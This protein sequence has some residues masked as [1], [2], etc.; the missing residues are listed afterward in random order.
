M[1][2]SKVVNVAGKDRRVAVINYDEDDIKAKT[3]TNV[4]QLH[5]IHILDRSGSM[6]REIDNLIDSVQ[7]TIKVIHDDDLISIIWFSSPGQYRTLIKGA[8]KTDGLDKLLD[9]LRSTIATTCF[10]DPLKEA[11]LIIDELV[12]L[13]PN[14]SI[15]LFT[16]GCPVIPWSIEE[17]EKRIFNILNDIKDKILAFN[18][19]GFGNWYN[20]DLLTKMAA[21]SEYGTFVHSTKIDEYL[22]IFNHN[23]EKISDMVF[24]SVTVE[25]QNHDIV[26]LTRKFSKMEDGEF[27]LSRINSK[28]NQFF[29][30]GQDERN[31][32][33][34]YQ[35]ETIATSALGDTIKKATLTNFYYSYAYNLYY[36]NRRQESLDI[37][38]LNVKDKF[39]V[40]SHFKSFTY[41]ECASHTK[42]LECAIYNSVGR[43]ISGECPDNYIPKDDDPCVMDVLSHLQK[44]K[45]LYVP[46]SKNVE[47][48]KRISR[49]SEDSFNVFKMTDKEVL[50][51]FSSFVYNKEH[52]NLSVLITIPGKV[53]LNPKTAKS[54]DLPSEI[55]SK[56]FRAY[57]IIKDGTLNMKEIEVMLPSDLMNNL[58]KETP[59]IF[60][61]AIE[62]EEIEGVKYERCILALDKLPIINRMYIRSSSKISEVFKAVTRMN[63]LEARQKVI[64]YYLEKV[65]EESPIGKKE[66]AFKAYT[67]DQIKVLMEHGL[68]KNLTYSGVSRAKTPIEECD[69]YE[70]R[71]MEFYISGCSS[72]PKVDDLIKAVEDKKKLK[73]SFEIMEKQ[74]QDILDL[75]SKKKLD[76]NKATTKLRNFLSELLE[77]CKDELIEARDYLNAMKMAKIIT[78]DWFSDL[79]PNDKGEYEYTE[80]DLTMKAKV[81][82]T[83]EYF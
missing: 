1:M 54:V 64:K 41:D 69:S 31:F 24:D 16:D 6:Y 74:R 59:Q 71:T 19:V 61:K 22:S 33:F 73:L 53:S 25:S 43:L 27:K 80:G 58:S 39:L 2:Y 81:A 76:I 82:R 26:Y 67:N 57:T 35:G 17:E 52:M 40:D 42:D 56:I 47:A 77:D 34:E 32:E 46:F 62:V 50:A 78:G 13:C 70:T 9:T 20:K 12:T 79:I 21:S 49:K 51:P 72:W 18:T 5:H 65:K 38:A 23:F 66:G 29:I 37:L 7:E 45:A 4:S 48:Y 63:E 68:D 55:D 30:V 8:K 36:S 14:I 15:T 60:S 10:S 3:S 44:G 75:I 83:T 28:K 11:K